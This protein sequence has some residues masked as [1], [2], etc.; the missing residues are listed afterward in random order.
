M[1]A[2]R[3]WVDWTLSHPCYSDPCH[4][5][6]Y[7]AKTHISPGHCYATST[8]AH[9]SVQSIGDLSAGGGF[10]RFGLHWTLNNI[11]SLISLGHCAKLIQ[12]PPCTEKETGS[13]SVINP[14]M[15]T[16]FPYHLQVKN[17]SFVTSKGCYDVAA[18]YLD[19]TH[20]D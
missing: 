12:K 2:S 17:S 8:P 20:E 6:E 15:A 9:L 7:G 13:R 10:D 5:I 18:A 1:S 14:R 11:F 16:E 4:K 19:S 3:S